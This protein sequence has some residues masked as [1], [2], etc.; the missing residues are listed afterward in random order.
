LLQPRQNAEKRGQFNCRQKAARERFT[1]ETGIGLD[2][3]ESR[4]N[5]DVKVGENIN[6]TLNAT[7][8]MAE[9]VKADL[10]DQA[11]EA[12]QAPAEST[13]EPTQE[14]VVEKP[15]EPVASSDAVP[16][17]PEPISDKQYENFKTRGKASQAV[18][19][20][21]V[22]DLSSVEDLEAGINALTD[23][24]KEVYKKHTADITGLLNAKQA[25]EG[26]GE[27]TEKEIQALLKK[28]R[29]PA[30]TPLTSSSCCAFRFS[31]IIFCFSCSLA[32][33]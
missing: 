12:A 32:V 4:L 20:G 31:S 21:I 28:L 7:D 13:V 24:Q 1:S 29:N 11:R 15:Q 3:L 33:L 14:P 8:E 10:E 16:A 30:C 17:A 23:R 19:K 26:L 5:D 2:E 27:I 9:S 22:N 25:K 18:I 6:E